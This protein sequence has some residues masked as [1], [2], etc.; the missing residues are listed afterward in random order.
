LLIVKNARQARG[1]P[2]GV[3]VIDDTT[4]QTMQSPVELAALTLALSAQ[5]ENTLAQLFDATSPREVFE[6]ITSGKLSAERLAIAAQAAIAVSK[7][8]DIGTFAPIS[9]P[10]LRDQDWVALQGICLE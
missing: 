7:I 3:V 6:Y 2:G 10:L 4:L 5:S 9:Q 8:D 1:F